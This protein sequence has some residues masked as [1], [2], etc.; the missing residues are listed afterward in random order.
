MQSLLNYKTYG[1]SDQ[2]SVVIIHGLFGSHKNWS[3]IA[4]HLAQRYYVVAVD[5]RNHGDSFNSQEMNYALMALDV[6]KVVQ[7]L[8]LKSPIL[9]GHSMG[10][11]T[12]MQ[13][14]ALAPN[15]YS[16]LVVVDIAPIIYEHDYTDL[17]Q[18]FIDLDISALKN[19]KQADELLKKDISNEFLRLFLLQ[20]LANK[21]Q[22]WYWK[23]AWQHLS[24]NLVHIREA[25]DLGEQYALDTLFIFGEHS[26]YYRESAIATIKQ[27]F[28]ASN[29][30]VIPQGNHWLHYQ[31]TDC[32][33]KILDKQLQ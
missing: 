12:A 11:K 19:R 28:V 10:G 24:A 25:P 6:E 1:E 33:L 3:R 20:S 21:E 13:M 31:Q 32:F 7:H 5:C 22:A 30:E 2:Q 29:I 14:V 27:H 16:Q 17:I 4:K 23:N 9:L 15:A 18:P 26:E 8:G